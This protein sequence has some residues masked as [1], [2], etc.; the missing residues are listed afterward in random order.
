MELRSIREILGTDTILLFVIGVSLFVF[1]IILP[2][3]VRNLFTPI[4]VVMLAILSYRF[5]VES[6]IRNAMDELKDL[7]IGHYRVTPILHEVKW[8]PQIVT[9]AS[10]LF[11]GPKSTGGIREIFRDWTQRRTAIMFKVYRVDDGVYPANAEDFVDELNIDLTEFYPADEIY[12][13]EDTSAG[14]MVS[15]IEGVTGWM[16]DISGDLAAKPRIHEDGIH[17]TIESLN[18]REIQNF[19][20]RISRQI[21]D[22]AID[23]DNIRNSKET[24]RDKKMN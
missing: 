20:D 15:D 12:T 6:E 17:F 21:R 10:G 2:T 23:T 11:Y 19:A 1:Q 4:V 18:G 22:Q 16:R 7:E 14:D 8:R 3:S 9:S 24:I 13:E 5:A